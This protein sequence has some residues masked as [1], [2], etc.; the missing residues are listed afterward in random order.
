M[1]LWEMLES[2]DNKT[3]G[4]RWYLLRDSPLA[5]GFVGKI[6]EENDKFQ[7]TPE[8]RYQHMVRYLKKRDQ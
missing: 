4:V 2:Q 5:I 1:K 3:L 8:A 7:G 6:A